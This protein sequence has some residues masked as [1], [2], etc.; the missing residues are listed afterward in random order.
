MKMTRLALAVAVMVPGLASAATV[1]PI[2]DTNATP[3]YYDEFLSIAGETVDNADFRFTPS[4]AHPVGSLITFTFSNAPIRSETGAQF[5]FANTVACV[6]SNG[7]EADNGNADGALTISAQTATTV[8]YQVTTAIEDDATGTGVTNC[9]IVADDAAE[10]PDFSVAGIAAGGD[11]TVSSVSTNALGV[12]LADNG[13][14]A[15]ILVSA[16]GRYNPVVT[17]GT[18]TVNVQL[19]APKTQFTADSQG[20]TTA[21]INFTAATGAELTTSTH[22]QTATVDTITLSGDFSWLDRDADTD[23]IQ[24]TAASL[25]VAGNA[26]LTGLTVPNTSTAAGLAA[27]NG[28][29]I[30]IS[31]DHDETI[32]AVTVDLVGPGQLTIPTQTVTATYTQGTVAGALASD[33]GVDVYGINGSE[34]SVYGVPM[35]DA[36]QNLIYLDNSSAA[37]GA[38][39]VSVIDEGTVLG[40]YALGTVGANEIF[41][42]GGRFK[43][44]IN[45]AGDSISGGRVRLDIVTELNDAN[46]VVTA[47]YKVIS[48]DDRVPLLTSLEA[49]TQ[50]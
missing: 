16:D 3:Q 24:L 50:L 49:D 33:S 28:G 2:T 40:P 14:A 15:A 5:P 23:G 20:L 39:S 48:A 47:G 9:D 19:A 31:F 6:I 11:V 36:V 22:Q 26:A 13:T 21:R 29:T 25:A 18:Q 1:A 34:I 30:T 7:A 38:V 10:K 17:D 4:V 46:V 41:D 32:N 43:G 8:T 44:A 27:V 42:I 35:S 37:A 12:S 45:E